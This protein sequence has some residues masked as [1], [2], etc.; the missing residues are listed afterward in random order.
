[1]SPI[2]I[3]HRYIVCC[4]VPLSNLQVIVIKKYLIDQFICQIYGKNFKLAVL[5]R[6]QISISIT[7]LIPTV[8]FLLFLFYFCFI[9]NWPARTVDRCCW[10]FISVYPLVGGACRDSKKP[11][12]IMKGTKLLTIFARKA[13]C[14]SRA[15]RK[16]KYCKNGQHTRAW[17]TPIGGSVGK[18]IEFLF[19]LF[20]M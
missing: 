10:M 4:C 9:K 11:G 3:L 18:T 2:F 14:G 6:E 20:F 7:S 12:C 5:Y 1:M 15:V 19:F 13:E 17:S 8:I 16:Y